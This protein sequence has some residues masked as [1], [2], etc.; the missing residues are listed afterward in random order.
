MQIGYLTS[1]QKRKAFVSI[2]IL[3]QSA[4][5]LHCKYIACKKGNFS[6]SFISHIL[7]MQEMLYKGHETTALN[8]SF[9]WKKKM[10]WKHCY[11]YKFYM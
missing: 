4:K 3:G 9:T 2:S 10:Q 1:T 8:T 11:K 5:A 6:L 7:S